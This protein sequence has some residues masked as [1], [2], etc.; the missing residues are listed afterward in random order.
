MDYLQKNISEKI[1]YYKNINPEKKLYWYNIN[2]S[3]L[4]ELD[5]QK[6]EVIKKLK[7]DIIRYPGWTVSQYWD[8]RKWISTKN[9]NNTPHKLTDLA[10]LQKAT[11][12]KVIFVL[13]MLTSNLDNQI[14]MLKKAEN[15]WIKI[16]YVEMWNEFY[17]SW[18]NHQDYIKKFPTAKE[19]VNT[20]NIWTQKLKQTFPNIKIW[21]VAIS[22]PINNKHWKDWNEIIKNN[23]KNFDAYVYHIYSNWDTLE[24][25]Q[26]IV[27]KYREVKI[28]DNT[29]QIWITEYGAHSSNK[30]TKVLLTKKLIEFVK[31]EADISLIHFLYKKYD[32]IDSFALINPDFSGLTKLGEEFNKENNNIS[33]NNNYDVENQVISP[34]N[35]QKILWFWI[36]VNW[37]NYQKE[38]EKYTDKWPKDFKKKWFQNVRIRF[39]ENVKLGYLKNIVDDSLKVWL[40]PVVAF[41]A[42]DF[43]YNPD[44]RYLEQAIEI[45]KKVAE[46]LKNES[47]KVSFDLIIEP[48]KNLKKH[49]DMLY[50]FYETIIPIIRNTWWNNKNRIIFLA[51][52]HLANPEFLQDLNGV[53]QKLNDKYLMAEFHFAAAGPFRETN[54][55]NKRITWNGTW[56]IE[57]KQKIE[58]RIKIAYDWQQNTWIKIWFGAWM[59]GN[60]NHTY[61]WWNNNYSSEEQIAFSTYF[62][63]VLKKYKIPND[64]NADQKFYDIEKNNWISERLAILDNLI[65]IVK[66]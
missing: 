36:D 28:Q 51:P 14:E 65:K 58:N 15:L 63:K 33:T 21:V 27:A 24:S 29:K 18:E 17:L 7:T 26:N 19:Y 23:A 61:D 13:N 35:Y 57:E 6:I 8:W 48:W 16:E 30:D 53:F 40:V 11:N 41:W 59:P 60:Y 42:N 34:E 39:S 5:E 20:L 54:S 31:K 44:E 9:P 22:R 2:W 3:F 46:T 10:K 52:N 66:N 55:T 12:A 25:I 64:I 43:K 32:D 49:N 56:T 45:W 1:N 62:E 38:I 37:A 47:Y 4:P 50:K